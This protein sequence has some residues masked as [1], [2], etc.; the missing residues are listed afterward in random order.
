M[1]KRCR[2]TSYEIP[3]VDAVRRG[4][5]IDERTEVH[6]RLPVRCKAHHFPF[7]A[8]PLKAKKF[9]ELAVE[10]SHGV[11]ERN[12]QY[13]LKPPVVSSPNGCG[14]P[15]AAS[16]HDHYRGIAIARI[17][18]GAE[19]VRKVVIYEP[20]ARFHRAEAL[21]EALGA[22]ALVPHAS[23]VT[24]RIKQVQIAEWHAACRKAFKIVAKER[25]RGGPAETYFVKL[26][27]IG[28]GKVKTCTDRKL[29]KPGIML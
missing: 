29:R 17:G 9:R 24:H 5:R 18:V 6:P 15:R 11:R 1:C 23:E 21:R 2:S 14:F 8:V 3:R 12:R 10:V 16:V 4:A 7:I 22:A 27:R 20:H 13:M 26:V 19:R 25:P 28:L